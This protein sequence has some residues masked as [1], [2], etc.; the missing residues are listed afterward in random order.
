MLRTLYPNSS[1]LGEE[2]Q[3][4]KQKARFGGERLPFWLYF[5]VLAAPAISISTLTTDC[6]FSSQLLGFLMPHCM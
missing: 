4:C 2:V 1:I 5:A 3:I 6:T